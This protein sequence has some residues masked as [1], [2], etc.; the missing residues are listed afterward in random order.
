MFY[1]L[2]KI[3]FFLL[4]PSNAVIFGLLLG[5]VLRRLG[6]R[7]TGM[8][9]FVLSMSVLLAAAFT[10]L[11][12]AL[13]GPLENRF[14]PAPADVQPTGVIVL[15]GSIDTVATARWGAPQL[16]DGSERV[17]ALAE[18]A[19]RFPEARLVFSG[20]HMDLVAGERPEAELA[21]DMFASLGFPRGRLVLEASSR[22]TRENAAITYDR[23]KPQPGETWLLVTSAAHM[24]RAMGVFRGAGWTGL[25]AYPVDYRSLPGIPVVGRQ[26]AS[27]GLFLTDLA[28]KEWLGLAAYRFA[29][30]TDAL[31]PG[32]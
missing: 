25:V 12:S 30:Y 1:A 13:I 29:G 28:V 11:P 22:N 3:L 16:I 9:V 24:P 8:T 6:R 20:G 14:P 15:G 26:F 19:R 27:E 31:F 4:R 21:A 17:F 2:S 23:V 5:I 32:P 10:G 7:R 18:L